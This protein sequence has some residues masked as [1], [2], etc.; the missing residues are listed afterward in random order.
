LAIIINPNLRQLPSSFGNLK[1]IT[2]LYLNKNNLISI[3]KEMGNFKKL[4]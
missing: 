1:N 2:K 3:P 4:K